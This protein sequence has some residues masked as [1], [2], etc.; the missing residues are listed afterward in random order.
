MRQ[1]GEGEKLLCWCDR[2]GTLHAYDTKGQATC[3]TVSPGSQ[4]YRVSSTSK[5]GPK[6]SKDDEKMHEA[7]K[8]SPKKQGLTR[9]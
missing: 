5:E 8:G 9:L 6:R 2:S 4:T 1:Q 3:G 7:P